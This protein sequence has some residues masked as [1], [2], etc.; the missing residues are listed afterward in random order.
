MTHLVIQT[1]RL[2]LRLTPWASTCAIVQRQRLDGWATD[3][4]DEGDVVIAKMLH[5][6]G[7]SEPT[8][9]VARW[10]HRQVVERA[11]GLVIGG[12]GFF[13]PPD[14]AEVEIGYG[15]VSSRRGRGYATEAVNAMLSL[16]LREP[17]IVAVVAGTD[18]ENAASQRVLD[19]AGFRRIKS[20]DGLRYRRERGA[21]SPGLS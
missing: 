4:P 3:Y 13:G 16:A 2:S 1:P 10:G 14:D 5:A 17:R 8:A 11:T 12:V 7:Q 6:A 20:T 15:I 18:L 21:A 19:K 9:E